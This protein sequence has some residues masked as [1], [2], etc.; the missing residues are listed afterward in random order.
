MLRI[1]LVLAFLLQY[2][3]VH[4][5][6]RMT[7]GYYRVLNLTISAFAARA[8]ENFVILSTIEKEYCRGVGKCSSRTMIFVL[9]AAAIVYLFKR[10]DFDQCILRKDELH[11]E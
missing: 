5:Y 11:D 4:T 9:S 8:R 6:R 3:S 2:R 10:I 1:S 7:R